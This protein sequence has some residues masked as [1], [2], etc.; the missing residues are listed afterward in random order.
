MSK[1]KEFLRRHSYILLIVVALLIAG[2]NYLIYPVFIKKNLDL[3]EVPVAI[4]KIPG[5]SVIDNTMITTMSISKSTL[6]VNVITNKDNIVGKYVADGYSI[7]T[8]GFFYSESVVDEDSAFGKI[9]SS[10]EEGE[11]AYTLEVEN[12]HGSRP[13]LKKGQHINLYYYQEYEN[14]LDGLSYMVGELAENIRVLDTIDGDK[15]QTHVILALTD[16][17]LVDITLAINYGHVLPLTTWQSSGIDF[18]SSEYHDIDSLRSYLRDK[19]TLFSIEPDIEAIEGEITTI[20]E[21][22][23][24]Q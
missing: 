4:S 1:L 20:E 10:L 8:N 21:V 23:D 9:Y 14:E 17:Q 24:G 12:P 3:I 11:I 18:V 5:Q 22:K 13:I 15:G 6:P 19:S 16:E 7:P 2:T